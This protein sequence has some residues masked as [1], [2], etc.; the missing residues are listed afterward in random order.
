M[1]FVW[2]SQYTT[3]VFLN[4]L[5]FWW[6]SVLRHVGNERLHMIWTNLGLVLLI[7]ANVWWKNS[8]KG[9]CA[10]MVEN[11]NIFQR[12]PHQFLVAVSQ[13]MYHVG[14][15]HL[16]KLRL[17]TYVESYLTRWGR[18]FLRSQQLLS[19]TASQEIHV[20]MKPEVSLPC[21]QEHATGT[22]AR[23]IQSIYSHPIPLSSISIL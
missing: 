17:R 19:W 14:L 1:C 3:T 5:Y 9:S 2:L 16:S 15:H 21:L 7:V 12:R 4:R 13:H 20:S 18:V 22:R 23:R 8:K 10:E 6:R 11:I